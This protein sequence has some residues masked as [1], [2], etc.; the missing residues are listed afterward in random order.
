MVDIMEESFFKTA[1]SVAGLKPGVEWENSSSRL[2]LGRAASTE[3]YYSAGRDVD[4]DFVFVPGV[5]HQRS[6]IYITQIWKH[7]ESPADEDWVEEKILQVFE[8]YL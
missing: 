1:R 8:R 5:V 6:F 7:I 3:K 4:G 2:S